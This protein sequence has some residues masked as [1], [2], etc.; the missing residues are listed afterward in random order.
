MVFKKW[1]NVDNFISNGE[2]FKI[3]PQVS[4]HCSWWVASRCGNWLL[5]LQRVPGIGNSDTKA[6]WRFAHLL[7]LTEAEG[8]SPA[9]QRVGG[10]YLTIQ[11]VHESLCQIINEKN[12]C[13][14]CFQSHQR[15]KAHNSPLPPLHMPWCHSRNKHCRHEFSFIPQKE[16]LYVPSD[17]KHQ[18]I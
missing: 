14:F 1:C 13:L 9:P 2:A 16:G 10:Q 6:I 15:K 3:Q 11:W 18:C 5:S 17:W 8:S 12:E 4:E 7:L